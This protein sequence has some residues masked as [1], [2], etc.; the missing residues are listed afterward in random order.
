MKHITPRDFLEQL[1]EIVRTSLFP[2]RIFD[3]KRPDKIIKK[4]GDDLPKHRERLLPATQALIG[5]ILELREDHEVRT[6]LSTTDPEILAVYYERLQDAGRR[7]RIEV[8]L[9]DYYEKPEITWRDLA[10]VLLLRETFQ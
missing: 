3:E 1:S 8:H 6:L 9:N 10:V 5:Q 4:W 7:L 2:D